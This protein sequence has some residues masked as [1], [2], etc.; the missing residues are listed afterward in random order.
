M[1]QNNAAFPEFLVEAQEIVD[2]LG[3]DLVNGEIASRSGEVDTELINALFRNAHSLKGLSAM[4]GF[5]IMSTLAHALENVLDSMRLGKIQ[6][7]S[8]SFDVLFACVDKF[9]NLIEKSGSGSFPQNENIDELVTRLKFLSTKNESEKKEDKSTQEISVGSLCLHP[10]ILKVLTEYEEYRLRENIRRKKK[11]LY[12]NLSLNVTDFDK[13]LEKIDVQLKSKAE[14][15]TKLPCPRSQKEDEIGFDL[16]IS[17]EQRNDT[18]VEVLETITKDIQV[19]DT[20]NLRDGNTQ[21]T[22]VDNKPLQHETKIE[23]VESVIFAPKGEIIFD[24][25]QL[26]ESIVESSKKVEKIERAEGGDPTENHAQ[27]N[28]LSQTVR[29]D[30]RRLD[31]LMNLVGE[32]SVTRSSMIRIIDEIKEKYGFHGLTVD[33]HKEGRTFDRRL[34][35]LQAGILEVRMVPIANLFERM[36]LI[37]RK[38]ATE[39]GRQV[40]VSVHGEHTELDKLIIEDVSD[41]LMHLIRNA[42]DHGIETPERRLA[43]SKPAEGQVTLLAETRGN[44]VIVEVRDDG[45]G[46]DLENIKKVALDKG[47]IRTTDLDEMTPKDIFNLLFLPGF[48]TKASVSELSG[49]GVGLD[50]VKSNISRLSGVVDVRSELGVGTTFTLTLP[51]TLAIISA[52]IVEISGNTYAIPLSNVVETIDLDRQMI[53][54]IERQKVITVR[55]STVSLL[56]LAELFDIKEKSYKQSDFGVLVSVGTQKA[57]IMVDELV[58]QQDIVIKSLGHRLKNVYGVAGA[59]EL[60]NQKTILV[61]DMMSL[62]T[63]STHTPKLELLT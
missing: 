53:S 16:L 4:F 36:V 55:G 60:A 40:H 7:S 63:H 19:V 23:D 32:L 57:A 25:S 5:S 11:I 51:I 42:I 1:R 62:L 3:R 12:V 9:S 13:V 41:P 52:I 14:I 37:S 58:G 10:N 21:T 49:R 8:T 22:I 43:Q 33:L 50:V 17:V 34:T 15:I 56:N 2:T 35:E 31:Y 6:I 47:I 38:I 27:E 39:L 46:I 59:T 54:S 20:S 48:S 29:V 61:L 30:I 44:H 28:R 26:P 45:N 24:S 18:A